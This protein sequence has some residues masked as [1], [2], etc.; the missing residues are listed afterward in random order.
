VPLTRLTVLASE[1]EIGELERDGLWL[2]AVGALIVGLSL[3]VQGPQRGLTG[4]PVGAVSTHRDRF[5]FAAGVSGALLVALGSVLVM[6]GTFPDLWVVIASLVG[7][8]IAVCA[9]GVWEV[10]RG[11]RRQLADAQRMTGSDAYRDWH[12]RCAQRQA[13]WRWWLR[14]PFL[15][16]E[17]VPR[18]PTFTGRARGHGGDPRREPRRQGPDCPP[19]L[20][21]A[22]Q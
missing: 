8:A 18:Q 4:R 9:I 16:W 1:A 11:T 15:S 2:I 22:P 5:L 21:D 12:L 13:R 10:R 7:V 17:R 20:R 19:R 3:F 14:H 6:I